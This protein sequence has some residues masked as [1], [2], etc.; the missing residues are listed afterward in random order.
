MDDDEP[1]YSRFTES[2]QKMAT[3]IKIKKLF[4]VFIKN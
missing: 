1:T 2:H 3:K 4:F